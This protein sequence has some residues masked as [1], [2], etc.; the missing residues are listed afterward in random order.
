MSDQPTRQDRDG[1]DDREMDRLLR[2][3]GP[4]MARQESFEGQAPDAAF[5]HALR[6]RLVEDVGEEETPALGFARDLRARLTGDATAP[7]PTP[8]AGRNA[9]VIPAPA[10]LPLRDW[11]RRRARPAGLLGLAAALIA[12][13]VV[14]ALVSPRVLPTL[15]RPRGGRSIAAARLPLLS[16]NDITRGFQSAPGIGGGGGGGGGGPV[17][18]VAGSIPLP[19]SPQ[20]FYGA[21]RITARALPR[22]PDTLPAY[23]LDSA[24]AKANV[25]VMA[26]RVSVKA[27]VVPVAGPNALWNVA[28]DGSGDVGATHPL[29]SIAVSTITGET[30]Y[31]DLR[32]QNAKPDRSH[33]LNRASAVAVARAWLA[34]IGWKNVTVREAMPLNGQT[35][36]SVDVDWPGTRKAATT[37]GAT[38]KVVAD[39]HVQEAHLWPRVA[40]RLPVKTLSL[41]DA[42]AVLQANHVPLSVTENNNAPRPTAGG[43][44]IVTAVT[45]VQVLTADIYGRLY[46]MPAYRFSGTALFEAAKVQGAAP[47]KGPIAARWVALVPASAGS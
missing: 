34:L 15:D 5:S 20:P 45:V 16:L 47:L 2:D 22:E 13:V 44:G 9:A 4:L 23:R 25:E 26:R 31:H 24:P 17:S 41:R 32:H 40:A 38:V 33:P 19:D 30:I 46:L 8:A 29:H 21:L 14:F 28:A 6:A 35:Q 27:S 43:K 42:L 37:P 11:V 7:V 39:G 3:L 12:A 18:P 10:P 36:W 1:A